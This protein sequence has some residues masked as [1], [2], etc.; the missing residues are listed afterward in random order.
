MGDAME[1][2]A[3]A[4]ALPEGDVIRVLLEQH[5]Q[6]RDL[7]TEVKT[8]TGEEQQ[9]AF[10][11]LRGLLAVHET[12]EEMVLRPVTEK[13]VGEQVAEARNHEE[14]DANAVLAHLEKMSLQD[15]DF[16]AQFEAFEK[17]VD[18]HAESEEQEEFPQILATCDEDQRQTMGRKVKAAEAIAP[19]HP[20]PSVE[21]GSTQQR[22]VGPFAAMVDRAK[23]A[24]ASV[25]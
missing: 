15:P 17:A 24:I 2:R 11:A 12:A 20:H 7:F 9:G 16:A 4:R 8:H 14:Q 22:M 25:R 18:K 21:P 13:V 3:K 6:I 23:D 1:D 5:A 10:D 19:T